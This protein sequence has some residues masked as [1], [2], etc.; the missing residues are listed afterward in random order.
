MP[1]VVLV[2]RHCLV[3]DLISSQLSE[4]SLDDTSKEV[5]ILV[6]LCE[7]SEEVLVGEEAFL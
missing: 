2:V 7:C 5:V 1:T 6:Q 4:H 3:M